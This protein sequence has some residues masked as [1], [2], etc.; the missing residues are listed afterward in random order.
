MKHY[1][2]GDHRG[3][4]RTWVCQDLLVPKPIWNEV[5]EIKL[6]LLAKRGGFIMQTQ[7]NPDIFKWNF[8]DYSG[9]T[10]TLNLAQYI[11]KLRAKSYHK[12]DVHV[13]KNDL[14]MM[15]QMLE[16]TIE[17]P[18]RTDANTI[19]NG[20]EF[21]PCED[22]LEAYIMRNKYIEEKGHA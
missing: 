7:S 16:G 15:A 4:M 17:I 20:I 22:C 12:I 8:F 2:Q 13:W 18:H 11:A 5:T 1:K 19:L 3:F 9:I 6:T 10:Y 14:E 21:S